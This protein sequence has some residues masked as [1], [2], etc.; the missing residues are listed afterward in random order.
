MLAAIPRS[1]VVMD[2]GTGVGRDAVAMHDRAN[3]QL[4]VVGIEP[5]ESA[6]ETACATYPHKNIVLC[7]DWDAVAGLKRNRQI[8]YLVG[9]VQNLPEPPPNLRADFINCSAVLMFPPPEEHQAFMNGLHR[10][11]RPYRDVFLRFRT[12]GLRE[13]MTKIDRR[14]FFNQARMAGFAVDQMFDFPDPP[15]SSR[16]FSW[17]DYMLTSITKG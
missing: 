8:A 4:L 9:E 11:S 13:G 15:P 16:P 7:R 3:G 17:H 1:G 6:Y 12:E 5:D 14:V 10:L 2:I